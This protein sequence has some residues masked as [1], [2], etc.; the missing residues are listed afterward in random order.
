MTKLQTSIDWRLFYKL[1]TDWLQESTLIPRDHIVRGRQN[2]NHP[3][4]PSITFRKL[5]SVQLGEG[6][7]QIDKLVGDPGSE[8]V[9]TT[10]HRSVRFVV[11]LLFEVGPIVIDGKTTHDEADP[12]CDA[13]ALATAAQQD[14]GTIHRREAFNCF[15]LALVRALPVLDISE[16]RNGEFISRTSMDVEMA[17][18]SDYVAPELFDIIRSA[19][20]TATIKQP[21]LADFDQDFGTPTI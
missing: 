2:V 20:G 5:S 7:A 13:D 17:A 11:S 12:D 16:T 1:L 4:Y 14:L 3:K 6:P 18:R 10:Y 15:G 19:Q 8:K 21:G 9:E